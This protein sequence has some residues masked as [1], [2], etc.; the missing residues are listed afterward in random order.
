[1]DSN[2]Y[3][4][5]AARTLIDGPEQPLS[6]SEISILNTVLA[7]HARLGELTEKLKKNILHRHQSYDAADF[8][9]DGEKLLDDLTDIFENEKTTQ[10]LQLTD[11]N[12]MILWNVIGLLGESSELAELL[13]ELPLNMAFK[14]AQGL[15]GRIKWRKELGDVAWY[16]AAIATKLG[17]HLS[18][19]QE[20]NIDKLKKRFPEGFTTEDSINRV[21][22]QPE[23]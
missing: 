23:L 7:M 4:K 1:M 15:E 2:E 11:Q 9:D 20:A 3:Q 13:Q 22:V 21:D 10:S 14:N 19:I 17:L 12:T 5:L 18:N 8:L 6:N 16:H